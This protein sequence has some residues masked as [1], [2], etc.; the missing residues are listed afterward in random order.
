MVPSGPSASLSAATAASARSHALQ[1]CEDVQ[2]MID[3]NSAHL[4][5]LRNVHS[6]ERRS[7]SA[8]KLLLV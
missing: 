1:V 4:D 2:H 6:R 8:G 5:K 3:M 7:V